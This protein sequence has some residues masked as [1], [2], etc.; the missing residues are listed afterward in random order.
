[1]ADGGGSRQN[2]IVGCKRISLFLIHMKQDYESRHAQVQY[3]GSERNKDLK[4][5]MR[6]KLERVKGQMDQKL[7]VR[8]RS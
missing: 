6:K 5:A 8:G 2:G 1:M 3:Q 7:T 4:Q